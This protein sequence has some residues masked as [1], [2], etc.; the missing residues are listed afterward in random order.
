[1]AQL[2]LVAKA[3]PKKRCPKCRKWMRQRPVRQKK[4]N[5]SGYWVYT[6]HVCDPCEAVRVNDW[7]RGLSKRKKRERGNRGYALFKSNPA[8]YLFQ[9]VRNRQNRKYRTAH[10]VTLT[11]KEFMKE[12]GGVLPSRC[13]ILGIP[14]RIATGYPDNN[15][16]SIDRIDNARPY[17]KGNVAIMSRRAN[18]IKRDGTADEHRRIADWMD[19]MAARQKR[20]SKKAA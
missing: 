18:F 9:S 3:K 4:P 11:F 12:I 7:Y 5:G 15:S 1:M 17:E 8:K 14:M 10:I 13:P 2:A 20:P 16:I 19:A 6:Q